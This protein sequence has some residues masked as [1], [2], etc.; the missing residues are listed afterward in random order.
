V[1]E[2]RVSEAAALSIIEQADYYTQVSD[3]VL[4]ERWEEAVDQAIH[5]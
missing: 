3:L 1:I 4:G 5:S 2:L